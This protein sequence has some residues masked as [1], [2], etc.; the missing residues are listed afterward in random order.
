MTTSLPILLDTDIGTDVDDAIALSMILASP[1]IELRAVTTVSGDSHRRARIARKL[2]DLAGRSSVPVAAGVREP[3]L[4]QRN[5]LWLGHEGTAIVEPEEPLRVAKQHGVDLLIETVL[6]ERLEVIAIGP[7]SNLGVAIMKEPGIID[8]IPQL[9]VMGGTIGRHGGHSFEYNLGSDAEA[10]LVVLNAGIPTTLVPLD[11]T[12]RVVL[13]DD[14]LAP[15]R[16][17]KSALL[18]SLCAAIDI[19]A[20]VQ[21]GFSA[22]QAGFD[23]RTVS[24]LHDPLTVAMRIDPSLV[25]FESLHLRAQIVDGLFKLVEDRSAPPMQV[26]VDV[27]HRRAKAFIVERLA[28]LA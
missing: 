3:V 9:T 20:G 11:V 8:A 17:S 21:R 28:R 24:I 16:R 25:S 15:L 22:T 27:D 1:E 19:W 13:I 7:L 26:A 23:P 10:A 6:R 2:L 4:R 12:M 18:Q 5:F 14:D